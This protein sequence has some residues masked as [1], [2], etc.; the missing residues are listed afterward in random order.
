[1]LLA[2][3][4]GPSWLSR[5]MISWGLVASCGVALYSK[6]SF[7]VMRLALG[8]AEAGFYPG[9]ARCCPAGSR[10][11]SLL[12]APSFVL[13]S[14]SFFSL[15][16]ARA[17]AF[18]LSG[19]FR[20]DDFG[21]AY[22][23]VTL[24]SCSAGVVGGFLAWLLMSLDG[25]LGLAGWQ[26]LFLAEGVPAVALGC[27]YR[28][29]LP[30]GPRQAAFLAPRERCWLGGRADAAAAAGCGGGGGGHGA[31]SWAAVRGALA[32]WR[33]WYLGVVHLFNLCEGETK[34]GGWGGGRD[35]R[36]DARN[37]FSL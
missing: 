30:D 34:G 11:V 6:A 25:A 20:G 17:V 37:R 16:F 32:N 4:G 1:M 13:F 35:A 33:F 22:A 28:R 15:S 27:A 12:P 36:V 2:R 23:Y 9:S 5:I 21:D 31:G 19:W 3:Y 18:Y 29:L 10:E 7:L 14:F 24:G 26:W 8:V